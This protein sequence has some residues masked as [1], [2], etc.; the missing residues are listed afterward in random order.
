[1]TTLAF[2]E[3]RKKEKGQYEGYIIDICKKVGK[4]IVTDNLELAVQ[5]NMMR[6]VVANNKVSYR[7]VNS[8]YENSARKEGSVLEQEKRS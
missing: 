3:L 2:N 8:I 7:S 1:M 4:K 5:T 6:R